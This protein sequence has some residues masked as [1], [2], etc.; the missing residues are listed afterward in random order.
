MFRAHFTTTGGV[1]RTG[2]GDGRADGGETDGQTEGGGVMDERTKGRREKGGRKGGKG[3]G[4]RGEEG[5]GEGGRGEEGE[6]GEGMGNVLALVSGCH[7]TIARKWMQL[8]SFHCHVRQ[9]LTT[10]RQVSQP[11]T[12]HSSFCPS[13]ND[14]H[15]ARSPEPASAAILFL[16][17]GVNS[18]AAVAPAEIKEGCRLAETNKQGCRA[19][20]SA[21]TVSV[22]IG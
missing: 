2:E 3:E 18:D 17:R 5:K 14:S 7:R 20:G 12:S 19:S 11:G 22:S 10:Q 13:R 6:K 9:S 8:I 21:A 1:R 16:S 4:R 15:L